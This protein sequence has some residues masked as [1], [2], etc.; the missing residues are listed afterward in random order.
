M[1]FRVLIMYLDIKAGINALL[2]LLPCYLDVIAE[3]FDWIPFSSFE[4]IVH[5]A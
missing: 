1:S 5:P 4:V 2:L 3:V